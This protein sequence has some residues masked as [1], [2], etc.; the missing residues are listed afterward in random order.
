MGLKIGDTFRLGTA[1]F[2]YR[3]RLIREPDSATGGF[4]LGPRSIVRTVDLATSGLLEPG[5]LYD[6]RYRMTL[7]P[8]T[9]LP[10]LEAEAEARFRDQGLRWRDSRDGAPGVERFVERM[11][12]FLVL[13]G[14][15]GLAVGGIGISAAIRSYLDRKIESIAALKA[16]GAES[17]TIFAAYLMQVAVLTV[18]G[19]LLGLALGALLPLLA[20]P[21]IAA[22]MPIP[23][24]IT[25]HAAPLAEAALYGTLTAFLFA[26]WPLARTREVRAAALFRD[27]GAGRRARPGPGLIL[28]LALI[29]AALVGAALWFTGVPSLALG[30]LG[31]VAGRWSSSL[32]P[33]PVSAALSAACHAASAVA[34]ACAS[35]SPPSA[36]RARRQPR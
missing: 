27:L 2:T 16:M 34:P 6:T 13:V 14:L 5:T 7:P 11:G 20:G 35:P 29:L 36:A 28:A 26:L 3:A 12:S 24:A 33:L 22:S 31:G 30:T 4:G 15:A 8:G 25:L 32:S 19:V 23:V 1:T 18:I 21:A 9:D 17:G 10:A